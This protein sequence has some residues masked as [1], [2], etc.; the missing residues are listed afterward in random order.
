MLLELPSDE[1]NTSI[2]QKAETLTERK[3]L[4]LAGAKQEV[5]AGYGFL[6]WRQ[7][8]VH[9]NIAKEERLDF[10]HLACLTYV[11]WDHPSRRELARQMFTA[12]PSLEEKSIYSACVAG[13]AKLVAQFLDTDPDLLNRRGGY[14]D[15]E[16]LLYACYSRLSLEDRSTSDVIQLLLDR[17][18]NPSAHYRW[19]GIYPFSALTGIFGEGERGPINQPEHPDFRSLAKHLLD[20]GADV[21]DSQA[22]YNRMF[23]PDNIALEMLLSSGLTKDHVC[24]WWA[25]SN[26]RLIPNPE[27]TLDYQ[28]QWAVKSN[29]I[30]RVNLLLDH[31]ADATQKLRNDG[32]L[33]KIARTQG[34]NDIAD[35]LEVHGGKPYKLNKLEQFVNLCLTAEERSA[36]RMLEETPS[37]VNRVNK[38]TP[39]VMNNAAALGNLEAIE[40]MIDLGFSLHG[41]SLD[42]PLHHAAHNGHL[43]L[44]KRL[45]D[46][47]A[48]LQQRDAFFFSTPVGWA[49]AGSRDEVVEYLTQLDISFFDVVGLGDAERLATFL[50]TYPHAISTQL[51][52]TVEEELKQHA[53]AWQTPLAYAAMRG[54]PDMVTLLLERGSDPNISNDEGVPLK[55]LC[56]EDIQNLLP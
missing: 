7:L 11:W 27:K 30:E 43:Q 28:L 42:T 41:N 34:F 24:N 4:N 48:N 15:W 32:R 12:D 14:F 37:L 20:A 6:S 22:L 50:D 17:G 51:R 16:P 31:G 40:L 39:D 21:N 18:A 9:L 56:D 8:C 47:G 3:G 23:T 54:L 38:R 44:V 35:A 45:L 13:N 25:T 29:F 49:Q 19:G 1:N 26:S 55:K 46:L 10:E 52:D 2:L 53:N 5:A 36:R 33:T